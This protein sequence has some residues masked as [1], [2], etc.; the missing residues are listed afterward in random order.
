MSKKRINLLCQSLE[1]LLSFQKGGVDNTKPRWWVTEFQFIFS[2]V[3]MQKLSKIANEQSTV[4]ATLSKNI[5]KNRYVDVLPSDKYRVA[6]NTDSDYINA[7]Y[8]SNI[9]PGDERTYIATQAPLRTTIED[10]WHMIWEC[11]TN[12]LVMATRL[13]EKGLSK[14]EQYWPSSIGEKWYLNHFCLY[15]EE[16]VDINSA[17]VIR[18]TICMQHTF[19]DGHVEERKVLQ[20][21]YYGWPDHGVPSCEDSFFCL[22]NQLD[23]HI[24]GI[25]RTGVFCAIDILRRYL[26]CKD[27]QKKFDSIILQSGEKAV[28]DFL[29]E[30]VSEVV[31]QLRK[32]RPG[33]TSSVE[34]TQVQQSL[35]RKPIIWSNVA[36]GAALQLF[37]VTTLGQPFEVIKTQLAANRKD[38]MVTALKTIYSRGGI[39]GFY[40]GL[41]PW[42]WIEASTKGGVLFLA[43]N[44][45]S[46][47]FTSW[48]YSQPVADTV[49]GIFGGV[50]QAYTTMGF[51]TF[52]KT[53]EVTRE[54]T[55]TG[56]EKSTLEV[57]KE[58]F[59]T[60]GIPGIYRGVTAVAVRQATNWGSRFGL[61]R[62]TEM[63]FKGK[64]KDRKLSKW[65]ELG[66]SV[67]GGA[68]ACWNQPIEVIRIEM[69]S[70]LK[71]AD[72]PEKLNIFTCAKYIYQK[73]GILGFYRGVIPRVGLGVYLT[74]VMVFG[75]DQV[76][77]Y[78]KTRRESNQR[79]M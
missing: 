19:N 70:Q 73:N 76:K 75:G 67:V 8:I 54:K 30:T 77:E 17:P 45:A 50:A 61:A 1:S 23:K 40:Q 58:V 11:E 14:C 43:Q 27:F 74:C 32:R 22:L 36:V 60:K 18:R 62:V 68:L 24:I 12:V 71:A 26:P 7:S 56:K 52:M 35:K 66:A 34:S 44:E 59:R 41:I 28:P 3:V 57:A 33:M 63:L 39:L 15:L 20:F 25:G 48:G 49:G 31:L 53:V 65:E 55:G 16:E 21:Q 38:T 47:L 51:C 29:I 64:D 46:S 79:S 69:Q 37:E 42:A 72:R 5:E 9:F 78:F 4:I 2:S 13:I 10:F 6:L